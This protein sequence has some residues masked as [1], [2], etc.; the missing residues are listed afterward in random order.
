MKK[1]LVLFLLSSAAFYT[2]A[3]QV[4][5]KINVPLNKPFKQTTVMKTD[6]EGE[7][8]I[9]MDM[10]MKNTVTGVKKDGVNFVFESVTDAIKMD[11]D[12]GMMT[13][14][15]DS[16]NPSED[17]MTKMLGAEMEKLIGKKMVMTITEKGKLVDVA[18]PDGVDTPAG[19]SMESM[20]M[21]ASYPDHAVNPGDTW[22]SEIDSKQT[23]IKALNKYIG[24]DAEGYIIESTGDVFTPSDEKI[25]SFTSKYVLDEKTHYT[26]GAN[27]K[28]DMNAQGQKV[29]LE[30]NISVTQ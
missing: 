1:L 14:S 21:T 24:K 13:M 6:V 17:P 7:Q 22:N 23:K 4:E 8:S 27:M 10:N 18:M 2:K 26:K 3:Q 11:M 15:Y 9:I 12:A 20:G 30:M 19:Q 16:E 28:M 25:G 5:F 29:V